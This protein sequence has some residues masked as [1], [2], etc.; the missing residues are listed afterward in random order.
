MLTNKKLLS[1]L[2]GI[3]SKTPPCWFMRQAGRYLPEYRQLRSSVK[4]FLELCY[5][6]SLAAEVTLQPIRRFNMDAAI[7]FSD[8]LVIP[9]A[10]GLKVDFI[11]GTGPVLETITSTQDLQKLSVAA[12]REKLAPVYETVKLVASEL[13]T[14]VTLIGFAGSPWTVASYMV[15]GKSSKDFSKIKQMAYGNPVLFQQLMDILVDA[16]VI[17]LSAQIDAGAE[18]VQLFDSW[19]GVLPEKQFHQWVINPTTAIVSQLKQRYPHIPIIGFPKGSGLYY[20]NY[21]QTGVNAVSLDYQLPLSWVTENLQ[22]QVILQGNLDPVMLLTDPKTIER[23]VKTILHAFNS[24]PFIFNLGH[25]M[26]P[27]TPIEHV[28]A[29][30]HAIRH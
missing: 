16:T 3:T 14:H 7:L 13:P 18:V 6:P 26:L 10:L 20:K 25:G 19:S 29:M 15:E 23:E 27:P 12:I 1:T 5:T 2:S 30:I 11:E 9:D 21:L 4:S 17:H 22:Q 24:H 28:E 8:I